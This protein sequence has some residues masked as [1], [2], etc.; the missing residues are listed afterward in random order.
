M[1]QYKKHPLYVIAVPGPKKRW[2]SKGLIF[3]SDEQVTEIKR[4]EFQDLT[5][6]TKKEAEEHAL[7]ICR[8]WIDEQS[9]KE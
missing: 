7:K 8:A 5:F 1:H 9:V 4:F 6:G 3:E 2:S